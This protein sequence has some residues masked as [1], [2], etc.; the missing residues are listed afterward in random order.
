MRTALVNFIMIIALIGCA[1]PEKK[2]DETVFYPPLPQKPR[3]QFLTTI[4]SEKD[5]G[6]QKSSFDEFLFGKV[7]SIRHIG[8]PLDIG[9]VKDRIYVLDKLGDTI[10]IIDL[11]NKKFDLLD[12]QFGTIG[13]PAGIWI[14]EDDF[15]YI[16][17]YKR[18]HI[19]V[20]DDNNKFVR[21][22]GNKNTLDKPLDVAVYGD[23]VYV[24]DFN[25]SKIIVFDK[26]SGDFI[27][28]IGEVGQKEGTFYKPT[29][30]TVDTKGNL[31]VNDA[32]NFRI[33]KFDA[34]G[35]F[36]M[37]Y[38]FHSDTPG[39]FARP[40]DIAVAGEKHLY[41][42]DAAFENVQIFDANTSDALLYFGGY[43]GSPGGM[44]LPSSVYIDY[45]N[46][47]YFEKYADK[48]FSIEYLIYVGNRF[49]ARKINVY[50]FG[51]WTGKTLPGM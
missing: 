12:L 20:F 4:S 2:I 44:Y 14:S 17:D 15:K 1:A 11:K 41:V 36:V 16:A 22:Y 40:K 10:I 30:I 37:K 39:G 43:A 18:Q 8:T 6:K 45:H 32:F 9:A 26:D 31:F 35:D 34:F 23:K 25:A 7:S 24:C 51:E 19:I 48:N 46:V 5:I 49:G 29:H 27:L 13:K 38:G 3:L 21:T 50:G 42:V 28:A 47:K 33:Q